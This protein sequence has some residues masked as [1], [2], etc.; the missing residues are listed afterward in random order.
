MTGVTAEQARQLALLT[1]AWQPPP[2]TVE[3]E[4]RLKAEDGNNEHGWF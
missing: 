2:M 3:G 1:R 4:R